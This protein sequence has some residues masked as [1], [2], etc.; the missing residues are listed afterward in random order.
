M[1]QSN[2][3]AITVAACSSPYRRGRI[4]FTGY[5]PADSAP[6]RSIPADNKPHP[7]KGVQEFK[8]KISACKVSGRIKGQASD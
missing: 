3:Y 8:V 5:I 2:V 4:E 6:V 1:S 7:D